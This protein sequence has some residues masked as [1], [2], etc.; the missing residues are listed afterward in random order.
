M[1]KLSYC[2]ITVWGR[3]EKKGITFSEEAKWNK[4]VQENLI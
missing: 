2:Y 3:G 1:D 4:H